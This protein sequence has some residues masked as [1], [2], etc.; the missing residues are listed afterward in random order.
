V[1]R[2]DCWHAGEKI[3][4]FHGSHDGYTRLSDPVTHE[5]WLIGWPDDVWMVADR[6]T[7]AGSHRLDLRWHLAPECVITPAS[8]E[9]ESFELAWS[10]SASDQRIQIVGAARRKWT[11]TS[12]VGTF[13]P[14]YGAI[15]SAPVL[16]FYHEGPLPSDF[17]TFLALNPPGDISVRALNA[18]GANAYLY[19]MGE[20]QRLIFLSKQP[21]GWRFHALASDAQLLIIQVSPAAVEQVLLSGGCETRLNGNLLSSGNKA[22]GIWEAS[23]ESLSA[24]N[25][26]ALLELFGN[27]LE[28]PSS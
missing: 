22:D 11:A 8:V 15:V 26:A 24:T 6:A 25:A 9:P 27:A 4:I 2:V 12:E 21:G 28:S 18:E 1:T 10:V 17:A 5:R 23:G 19:T 16:H 14:T 13:S 20:S 3:V 7:G